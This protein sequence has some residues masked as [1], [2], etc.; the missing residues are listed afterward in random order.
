ME[1]SNSATCVRS[2]TEYEEITSPPGKSQQMF[3]QAA[4]EAHR[5]TIY[6]IHE[7]DKV[8]TGTADRTTIGPF[9]PWR[10]TFIVKIVTTRSK[11]SNELVIS[12]YV[13]M[14]GVVDILGSG[15]LRDGG[16]SVQ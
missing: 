3:A 10:K 8:E 2:P 13:D 7:I 4:L 6:S 15:R 1:G 14:R 12:V 11:M 9:D 16:S 5:L